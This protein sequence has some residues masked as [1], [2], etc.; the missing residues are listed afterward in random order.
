[1]VPGQPAPRP[2]IY[3]PTPEVKLNHD[4]DVEEVMEQAGK[5]M[6][7]TYRYSKVW[8]SV[9]R[10]MIGFLETIKSDG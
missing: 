9:L 2:G 5:E 4:E 7:D 6:V 8:N 10:K 3:L 1:L